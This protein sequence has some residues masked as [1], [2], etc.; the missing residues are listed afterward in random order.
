M[1][2]TDKR[3]Y[4][5]RRRSQFVITLL[6]CSLYLFLM[7]V[8]TEA[9]FDPSQ[10]WTESWFVGGIVLCAAAATMLTLYVGMRIL[11]NSRPANLSWFRF[12]LIH[13]RIFSGFFLFSLAGGPFNLF[14]DVARL[15]RDGWPVFGVLFSFF[16]DVAWMY[17]L[18]AIGIDQWKGLSKALDVTSAAK[19]DPESPALADAT[20]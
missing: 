19:P 2:D 1:S 8:W 17:A 4:S 20:R 5:I 15:Q 13:A 7:F 3:E 12:A 9:M 10:S 11:R 18:A 6:P 14:H 16:F